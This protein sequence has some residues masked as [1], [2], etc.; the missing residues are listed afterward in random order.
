MP[1]KKA[2]NFSVPEILAAFIV[3]I[4]V[5]EI[6]RSIIGLVQVIISFPK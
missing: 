5:I 1:K 2:H 6:F 3:T 4:M